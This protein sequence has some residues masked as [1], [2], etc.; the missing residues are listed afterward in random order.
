MRKPELVLLVAVWEFMAAFI[1]MV[2][3]AAVLLLAFPQV[4][5]ELRYGFDR[6]GYMGA[7]FGLSVACIILGIY[8]AISVTG[9]IGL[10]MGREWGR[11]VSI[12][13][14]S[15]G[16]FSIPFGTIIGVLILIYLTRQQVR[17][18]FV[19]PAVP[20]QPPV[21]PPTAPPSPPVA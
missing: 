9:G 10:L 1:A 15:L 4:I 17:E 8:I 12:V 3:L 19:R 20:V 16:L 18:Y 14:A 21:M 6:T 11:I 5:N 13:Q 2:G 7:M